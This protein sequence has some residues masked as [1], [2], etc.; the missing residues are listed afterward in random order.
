MRERAA[1]MD[2]ALPISSFHALMAYGEDGVRTWTTAPPALFASDRDR[3]RWNER[4]AGKALDEAEGAFRVRLRETPRGK[5]RWHVE[6]AVGAQRFSLSSHDDR[7][8]AERDAS[9]FATLIRA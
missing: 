1:S 9:L 3:Q 5:R 8:A 6:I 2:I 4:F 7:E